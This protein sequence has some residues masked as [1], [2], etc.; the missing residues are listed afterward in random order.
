MEQF[1]LKNHID[2]HNRKYLNVKIKI[3]Y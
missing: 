1:T 2:Q 3:C